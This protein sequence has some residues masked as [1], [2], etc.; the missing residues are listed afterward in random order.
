[1]CL[2][3][4]HHEDVYQHVKTHGG[5]KSQLSAFL[6]EVCSDIEK[7]EGRGCPILEEPADADKDKDKDK[8]DD[9]KKE[10]EKKE[11]AKEKGMLPSPTRLR[12]VEK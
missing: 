1:M 9:K 4:D 10:P 11:P 7:K 3:R 5:K 8:A 12:Q 2:Q 6:E